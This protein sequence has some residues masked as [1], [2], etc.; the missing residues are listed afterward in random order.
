LSR[1]A[2]DFF[3]QADLV[4]IQ[5]RVDALYQ[6]VYAEEAGCD[7][8][9][10]FHLNAGF[11]VRHHFAFDSKPMGFKHEPETHGIHR[12]GMAKGEEVRRLFDRCNSGSLSQG[13]SIAFGEFSAL[14]PTQ[15][16][17]SG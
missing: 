4:Q 14:N 2:P 9:Q 17:R 3:D 1:F 15:G 8:T 7:T 12:E 6:I 16:F 5:G 10:S 11:G 13:Q